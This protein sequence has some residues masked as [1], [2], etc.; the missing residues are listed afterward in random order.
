MADAERGAQPPHRPAPPHMAIP[1]VLLD[2]GEAELPQ[3]RLAPLLGEV[4]LRPGSQ[5]SPWHGALPPGRRHPPNP[6]VV[7]QAPQGAAGSAELGGHLRQRPR[8]GDQPV[9]QVG[10]HAEEAELGDA[11]GGALVGGALAL[12]GEQLPAGRLGEVVVGDGGA[13][14]H[15]GGGQAGGELGDAPAVVEQGLQARAQVGEAQASG[16][17]VELMVL[18]AVDPNTALDAQAARRTGCW[19]CCP[20]ARGAGSPTTPGDPP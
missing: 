7:E 16:L 4:C 9:L 20:C 2:P 19:W 1:Q 18:A 6:V 10:P 17:L 8:V 13:D 14:G 15:L 5:A 11:G 3:A 12:A